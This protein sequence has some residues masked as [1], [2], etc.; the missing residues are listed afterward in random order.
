[1][2]AARNELRAEQESSCPKVVLFVYT[3]AWIEWVSLEVDELWRA[4]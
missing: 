3:V 1:M 4:V 2:A